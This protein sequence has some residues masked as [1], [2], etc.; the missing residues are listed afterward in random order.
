MQITV[1]G[2]RSSSDDW[3]RAQQLPASELPALSDEQRTVAEKLGIS[4][5]AYA[6][7]AK[8]GELSR[9]ELL[10]KTEAFGQLLEKKLRERSA[11]VFIDSIVLLTFEGKFRVT[12]VAG[13]KEIRFQIDEE[14]VDDLLQSGDPEL[15]GR[16][17]RVIDLNLPNSEAARAS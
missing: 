7:S 15:E 3:F 12:A 11:S 6:R 2:S 10:T 1:E 9:E 8:A 17:D 4:A 16:L 14:L 5:E 13:G